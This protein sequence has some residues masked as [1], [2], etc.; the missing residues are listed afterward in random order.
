MLGRNPIFGDTRIPQKLRKLLGHFK[1]IIFIHVKILEMQMIDN[2]GEDGRRKSRNKGFPGLKNPK[3]MKL[4]GFGPS[5]HKT[6]I[7]LDQN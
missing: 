1:N 2:V 4:G 7:L 5:H 6:E 3:I